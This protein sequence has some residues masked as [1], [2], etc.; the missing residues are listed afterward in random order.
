MTNGEATATLVV[1]ENDWTVYDGIAPKGYTS[2]LVNTDNIVYSAL[3]TKHC[4]IALFPNKLST[5][6]KKSSLQEVAPQK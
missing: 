4:Q 3:G 6:I 1:G 5:Q 2:N